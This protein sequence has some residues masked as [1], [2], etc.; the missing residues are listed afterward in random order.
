VETLREES[1]IGK[2]K[3]ELA[4]ER[5]DERGEKREDERGGERG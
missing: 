2:F 4:E 5:Q 3:R 1:Q